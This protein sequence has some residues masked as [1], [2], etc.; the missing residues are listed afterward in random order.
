MRVIYLYLVLH[1]FYISFNNVR[2]TK[3]G[4]DE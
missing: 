2:I 3:S 4:I 1:M